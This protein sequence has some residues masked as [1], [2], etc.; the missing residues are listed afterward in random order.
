MVVKRRVIGGFDF[1]SSSALLIT[2]FKSSLSLILLSSSLFS[3]SLCYFSLSPFHTLSLSYPLPFILS[4][5]LSL[6][7]SL[8][9]FHS[10]QSFPLSLPSNLLLRSFAFFTCSDPPLLP[11]SRYKLEHVLQQSFECLSRQGRK[12]K[13]LREK[14]ERRERVRVERK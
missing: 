1:C 3:L 10:L 9:L 2:F 7:F 12:R 14:M 5:S 8:S 13:K 4:L 11:P 6:S